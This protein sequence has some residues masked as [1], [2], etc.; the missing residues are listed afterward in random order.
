MTND[1]WMDEVSE[2]ITRGVEP[3]DPGLWAGFKTIVWAYVAFVAI[4]AVFTL[5]T[6]TLVT[7]IHGAFDWFQAL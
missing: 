5:F 3:P 6:N 2:K 1:E 4:W 7:C